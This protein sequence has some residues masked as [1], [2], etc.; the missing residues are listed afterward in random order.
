[1]AELRTPVAHY[2]CPRPCTVVAILIHA[3][4]IDIPLHSQVGCFERDREVVGGR[5]QSQSLV[6]IVLHVP[7]I[8]AIQY[9]N[10]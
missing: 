1:M 2:M 6:V 4:H 5:Q 7:M 3:R 8:A 10:T 9:M